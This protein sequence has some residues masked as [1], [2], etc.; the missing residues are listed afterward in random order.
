MCEIPM[1]HCRTCGFEQTVS[2]MYKIPSERFH[3]GIYR[4]ISGLC[5]PYIKKKQK[6]KNS[7]AL[8]SA[9]LGNSLSGHIP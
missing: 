5:R 6:T 1:L 4:G 9:R 7:V 3:L 2:Y 8:E